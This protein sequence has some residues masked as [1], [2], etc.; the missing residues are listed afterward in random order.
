MSDTRGNFDNFFDY[1]NMALEEVKIFV[2]ENLIYFREINNI[3]CMSSYRIK[4]LDSIKRKMEKKK[5]NSICDIAGI[6]VVFCDK[7]DEGDLSVLDRK[8]HNLDKTGFITKFEDTVDRTNNVGIDIITDFCDYLCECAKKE[9]DLEIIIDEKKNYIKYPK[10]TGY[11]SMHVIIKYK[12]IPVELQIRNL[13][14]H[15]FAEYEHEKRYKADENTRAEY[16]S[17][18]D[19]C[20]QKLNDIV[21]EKTSKVKSLG[22]K[23]RKIG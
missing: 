4:S 1:Y 2:F 11:Q 9:R 15:Y 16:N 18:C 19:S 8:I 21:C 13:A 17:V 5:T 22:E 3:G 10:D 14:Q 6:R 7:S 23:I 20:A 12:G